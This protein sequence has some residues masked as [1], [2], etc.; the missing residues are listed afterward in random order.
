MLV[1]FIRTSNCKTMFSQTSPSIK[2]RTHLVRRVHA[3]LRHRIFV[4][5]SLCFK[6]GNI[7]LFGESSLRSSAAFFSVSLWIFFTLKRVFWFFVHLF[8]WIASLLLMGKQEDKDLRSRNNYSV[9]WEPDAI[10]WIY[11]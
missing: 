3:M 7:F 8:S 6:M 9:T 10:W 2:I 11:L 4:L 1:D 5:C